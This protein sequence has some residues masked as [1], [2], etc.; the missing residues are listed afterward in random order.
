MGFGKCFEEFTVGDIYRHWPGRTLCEMD[1][2]LFCML[3][4]NHNPLH[5]D[6]HY[7]EKTQHGRRL[8][9]GPLVFSIAVGMSVPEVSGKCIA[10]LEYGRIR[11]EAPVFHGDTVYAETE[12]LEKKE[13]RSKADRGV[14]SVETRVTNQRG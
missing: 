2:T 7:A 13:S 8:V 5:I 4:M 11:H 9:S 3:T 10:N 12:V 14:V 6:G 1:D